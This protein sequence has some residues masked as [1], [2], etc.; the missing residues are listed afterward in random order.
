[1][2]EIWRALRRKHAVESNLRAKVEKETLL[3]FLDSIPMLLAIPV[4]S[5]SEVAGVDFVDRIG[6][7]GAAREFTA[8]SIVAFGVVMAYYMLILFF[9]MTF[10][11]ELSPIVKVGVAWLAWIWFYFCILLHYD[12][13]MA[14]LALFLAS[15]FMLNIVS[16]LRWCYEKIREGMFFDG[17]NDT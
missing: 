13:G 5:L 17:H 15:F 2:S 4:V 7:L 6:F 11:R 1:M 16:T 9:Q 14:F 3:A 12:L 10:Y 8:S